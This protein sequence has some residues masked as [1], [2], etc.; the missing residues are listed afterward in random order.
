[1]LQITEEFLF[2]PAVGWPSLQ[3]ETN[4]ILKLVTSRT[5]KGTFCKSR[6]QRV[7]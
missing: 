4:K 7:T 1:M 5:A 6:T 2:L 3:L